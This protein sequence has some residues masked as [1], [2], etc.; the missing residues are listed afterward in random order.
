VSRG[1]GNFAISNMGLRIET[2]TMRIKSDQGDESIY[3]GLLNARIHDQNRNTHISIEFQNVVDHNCVRISSYHIENWH[4]K[5]LQDFVKRTLYFEHLPRIPPPPH[6]RRAAVDYTVPAYK[7][8]TMRPSELTTLSPPQNIVPHHPEQYQ[9]D[10]RFP[11]LEDMFLASAKL[12]H[13]EH[14][15]DVALLYPPMLLLIGYSKNFGHSWCQILETSA[16]PE[17]GAPIES[18]HDALHELKAHRTGSTRAF[19]DTGIPGRNRTNTCFSLKIVEDELCLMVNID[20]L[21]V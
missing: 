8:Q 5:R 6:F 18:W 11:V 4:E 15:E 14:R 3:L 1:Y 20:G 12:T 9:H 2:D 19:F 7:I 16:N 17:I 10:I 13:V 21:I